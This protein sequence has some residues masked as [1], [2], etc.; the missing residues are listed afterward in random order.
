MGEIRIKDDDVL[1]CGSCGEPWGLHQGDIAIYLRNEDQKEGLCVTTK[2]FSVK[3]D[4]TLSQGN[5]SS[6]RQG[7]VIQFECELCS[8]DTSLLISQH[9]GRTFIEWKK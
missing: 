7:L 3:I 8:G 2:G 6:R 9:K 4:R 1:C 5:P